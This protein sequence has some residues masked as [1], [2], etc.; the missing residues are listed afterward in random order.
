M[1]NSGLTI[2]LSFTMSVTAS[3]LCPAFASDDGKAEY[4]K[5]CI[6]CHASATRLAKKVT[7]SDN[8]KKPAFLENFLVTHHAPDADIRKAIITYLLS[9]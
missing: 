1:K 7:G 9:L 2:A 4:E 3:V 5:T 6:A 8:L